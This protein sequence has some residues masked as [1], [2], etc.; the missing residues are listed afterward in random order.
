MGSQRKKL[1]LLQLLEHIA[2]IEWIALRSWFILI[3][4]DLN[5]SRML[6]VANPVINHATGDNYASETFSSGL[7]LVTFRAPVAKLVFP[8]NNKTLQWKIDRL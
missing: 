4:S 7:F 2:G 6:A 8:S 1:M 3:A 5:E